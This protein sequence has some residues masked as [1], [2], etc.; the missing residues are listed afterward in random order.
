M[1][2]TK[3]PLTTKPAIVGNNV[4]PAANVRWLTR[5]SSTMENDKQGRWAR[6]AY[7]GKFD[8]N[9]FWRGKC[10][11]W[12]IAWIKKLIINDEIKFTVNYLYPS[13]GKFL[14]DNVAAAKKEVNKTFRWFI[15]M[16]V[17]KFGC[18]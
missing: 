16:C 6:V 2:T 11:R 18:R 15:K 3:L 14:F 13:N 10:C 7:S 9:G 17:G 4:L 5:Y 12:E 1:K 8:N